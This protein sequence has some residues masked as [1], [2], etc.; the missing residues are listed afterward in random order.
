MQALAARVSRRHC[1]RYRPQGATLDIAKLVEHEQRPSIFIQIRNIDSKNA[2]F[3]ARGERI[4]ADMLEQARKTA[5]ADAP[6]TQRLVGLLDAYAGD[7]RRLVAH[8][9][10][11]AEV[12]TFLGSPAARWHA[13]SMSARTG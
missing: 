7:T 5:F 8:S 4:C 12:T 1:G 9:P 13:G 2:L 11:L 3:A 10:H 6:L